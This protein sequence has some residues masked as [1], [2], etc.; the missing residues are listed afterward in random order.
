MADKD[1]FSPPLVGGASLLVIFAVLTLTVFALLS[2]S[3]AQADHRLG[4]AASQSVCSYYRADCQAEAILA[5]LRR[6]QLPQGVIR[7]G[8][9]FSYACPISDAQE[10][11]VAVEIQGS[12]YTILRWQAVSTVQ[13]EADNS[14]TVWDG[15]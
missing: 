5:Q 14:L 12:D 6:G 13:W 2:L 15:G 9:R 4:S 11:R 7:E 3:A 10:L 8:D 1:R